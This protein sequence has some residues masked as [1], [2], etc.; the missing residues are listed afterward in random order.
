M[1]LLPLSSRFLSVLAL[2]ALLAGPA[3]A[4]AIRASWD[5]NPSEYRGQNNARLL[6]D[7]PANAGRTGA[8]Y[9]WGTDVYS[10]DS[11]LCVAAVHAGVISFERGGR[12][13]VTI[14]PGY[15]SYAPSTNHGVTSSSWG[16]WSGSFSV[17]PPTAMNTSSTGTYRVGQAV[18]ILWNGTWYP[19]HILAAADGGYQIHYDGYESSW[20][21]WV[22]PD[23]LQ[24]VASGQ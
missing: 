7:C 24:P 13:L 11:A 18:Q 19:G 3:S 4:Q 2:A 20:D 23:R 12:V 17:D 21:E 1:S 9:V 6:F 5:L 15:D 8:G 14:M 22:T 16:E 10:D